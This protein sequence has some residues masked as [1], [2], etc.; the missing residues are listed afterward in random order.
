MSKV[1]I[2]GA[3]LV[4]KTAVPFRRQAFANGAAKK[5]KSAK[6][7]LPST[8]KSRFFVFAGVWTRWRGVRKKS[9]PEMDQEIF[10]F[11]TCESNDVVRPIH[12]KAMPV[13]LTRQ[14]EIDHWLTSPAAEA[15]QLQRHLTERDLMILTEAASKEM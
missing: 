2:G 1:R 13:I 8:R 11:L 6:S 14:D 4:L 7:G 15:L 12:A 5:A 3:G 10:G 9:E